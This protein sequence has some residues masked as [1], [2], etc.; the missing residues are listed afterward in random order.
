MR[1][2]HLAAA[3]GASIASVMRRPVG[4]VAATFGIGRTQATC[5]ETK[6]TASS[7]W[8]PIGARSLACDFATT[9]L[10]LLCAAEGP[11]SECCRTDPC[12]CYCLQQDFICWCFRDGFPCA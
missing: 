10:D 1:R 3:L 8:G 11:C 5:A 7:G 6:L 12:R 2:R 4:L 9:D